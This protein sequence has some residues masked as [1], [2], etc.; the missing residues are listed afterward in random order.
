MSAEAE[1]KP[2]TTAPTKKSKAQ[3]KAEW[4]NMSYSNKM[5]ALEE[6]TWWEQFKIQ[7]LGGS[8]PE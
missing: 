2:K 5:H 4:D 7:H 1:K 8:L 3:K 6:L